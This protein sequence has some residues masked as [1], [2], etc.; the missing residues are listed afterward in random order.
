VAGASG[1]EAPA[2]PLPRHAPPVLPP[3]PGA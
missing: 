3:A 2:G 1:A